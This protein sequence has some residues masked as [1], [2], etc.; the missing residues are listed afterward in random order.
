MIGDVKTVF[1]VY[2][3]W[4]HSHRLAHVHT[5]VETTTLG[6]YT[7]PHCT[8]ERQTISGFFKELFYVLKKK[9][10]CVMQTTT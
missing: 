4:M 6:V 2:Y 9:I 5:W 10:D 7:R 8:A 3:H 1:F